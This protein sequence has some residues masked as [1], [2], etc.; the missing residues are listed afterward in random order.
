[1]H[2]YSVLSARSRASSTSL[3]CYSLVV[4][5]SYRTWLLVLSLALFLFAAAVVSTGFANILYVSNNGS[6]DTSFLNGSQSC[7]NLTLFWITFVIKMTL[8]FISNQVNMTYH[9]L[10]D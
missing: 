6:N 3:S 4:V 1:M 7:A 8:K 10:L 9:Q 5:G 2:I